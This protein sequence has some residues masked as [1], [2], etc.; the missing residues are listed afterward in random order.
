MRQGHD[1]PSGEAVGSVSVSRAAK[2]HVEM[3]TAGGFFA[4]ALDAGKA[5]V[6]SDRCIGLEDNGNGFVT[7]LTQRELRR[8]EREIGRNRLLSGLN[9][10]WTRQ[11][12]EVK[13]STQYFACRDALR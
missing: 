12:M 4:T 7:K 5:L 6:A 10:R 13:M 2:G 9:L 11:K 3:K 8:R 1:L